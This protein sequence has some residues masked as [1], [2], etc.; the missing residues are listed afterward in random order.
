[1]FFRRLSFLS[2]V[3]LLIIAV[4]YTKHLTAEE[5]II[6]RAKAIHKKALTLDTHIDIPG[7]QYA[8]EELD[9][10]IDNPKLKCDLV[11]MNKGGV[12]GVFLAVHVPQGKRDG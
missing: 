3:A 10:G 4:G 6:S 12:D 5:Q 8:T 7:A 9:P 1:M 2:L 11:K